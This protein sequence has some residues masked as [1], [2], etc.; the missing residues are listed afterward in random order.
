M[1]E[2]NLTKQQKRKIETFDRIA[3]DETFGVANEIDR[4]DEEVEKVGET[5]K[6]AQIEANQALKIAE[7]TSKQ[8]GP[9]GKMGEKG[10]KGDQ[11]LRGEKG[12]TGPKGE[13]GII[14]PQ[15]LTGDIGP[16]GKSG[17][18]GSPDNPKDIV[19]KLESL[20]GDDRLDA[21]AIKNLPKS[22]STNPS[23]FSGGRGINLYVDETKKGL[24]KSLNLKAG[25]G[26]VLTYSTINGLET[27]TI[28]AGATGYQSPVGVVDGEN[29]TFTFANTP[30]AITVDG[31]VMRAIAADGTVNWVGTD[32]ITLSI[33]PTYEIFS[34]A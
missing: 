17:N 26:V 18:D 1:P 16:V 20:E 23:F 15:G 29:K 7:E 31:V 33:A 3:N 21:S 30:N 34:I 9:T 22:T 14:G 8:E 32:V 6:T 12:D 10:D 25:T 27:V 4:L 13:Q 19:E 28:S 11:G 5:A 24:V 2:I